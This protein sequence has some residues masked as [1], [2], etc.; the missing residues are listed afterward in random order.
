MTTILRL[1]ALTGLFLLGGVLGK[2]ASFLSGSV[3]LVWP[4]AGIALAAILLLGYRFWPGIALGAVLFS[5]ISGQSFGFFMLGIAVGNT[6]GAVL[7]AYLLKRFVIFDN[8]MLRTRD[9]T[10]FILLACGLGTTVNALFNVVGLIYAKKITEDALF[11][12]FLAWWVPNALAMLVVTPVIITWNT[13]ATKRWNFWRVT[14]AILCG[15]GLVAGTLVSFNT[16]FVY[17][18]QQYPLAYLPYPFL[19]WAALRFGPRGATAGT[20]LVATLAILSLVNGRG[21]FVAG[22]I[23]DSLRLLGSYIGIVAVSNLL[24]ASATTERRKAQADVVEN[25]KRLR[26]VVTDQTDLICR[27]KAD[28]IITFVNP[29]FAEFLGKPEAGLLG[30]SFFQPMTDAEVKTLRQNLAALTNEQPLWSFDRRAEAADGHIEWQ[31]CNL[32]RLVHNDSQQ[33]EFQAVIQNI[34]AR[35]KAEIELQEAKSS[36]EK[37]NQQLQIA[38]AESRGMA[39]RA[40]RDRKSTRLNSS[41]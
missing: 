35:K 28:G 38:A 13:P 34:T 36:L 2:K 27:F 32:R 33:V 4:S 24:L 40:N 21:P 1:L 39:E 25:E 6:I 16:W 20:L 11:S 26:A 15:T 41:H 29:A 14:E 30:T 23:E 18:L 37:V 7:C 5:A 22:N 19:A 10:G 12:N 31:Q 3:A 8:A 9:A 17:G